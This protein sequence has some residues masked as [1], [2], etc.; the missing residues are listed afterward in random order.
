MR[1]SYFDLDEDETAGE[2][3]RDLERFD[4]RYLSLSDDGVRL[5]FFDFLSNG[6]ALLSRSLLDDDDV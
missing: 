4:E 5:D 3:E 6:L 2:N 1:E